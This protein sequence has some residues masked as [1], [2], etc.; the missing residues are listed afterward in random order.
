MVLVQ[1]LE[2]FAQYVAP[3]DNYTAEP[4]VLDTQSSFWSK[5]APDPNF[6]SPPSLSDEHEKKTTRFHSPTTT[7]NT[8]TKPSLLCDDCQAK[9]CS[10]CRACVAQFDWNATTTTTP[11]SSNAKT[12]PTTK[13]L[14]SSMKTPRRSSPPSNPALEQRVLSANRQTASAKDL[15]TTTAAKPDRSF[16]KLSASSAAWTDQQKKRFIKNAKKR[17][18]LLRARSFNLGQM[19]PDGYTP[20]MATAYNNNLDGLETIMTVASDQKQHPGAVSPTELLLETDP[21]GQSALHIC[22][23]RGHVEA[24]AFIKQ[25]MDEHGLPVPL[26]LLGKTPLGA[27]L[28]SPDPKAVSNRGSMK[29]LLY[30]DTDL[31]IVGNACPADER[32]LFGHAKVSAFAGTSEVPGARVTTEDYILTDSSLGDVLLLAVIDGHSDRGC[33]AKLVAER[34]IEGMS[35][36]IAENVPTENSV[37]EAMGTIVCLE[38]DEAVVDSG[39][40]GGA[41][42]VLVVVTETQVV[43]LNVGDCRCILVQNKGS[44]GS[45]EKFQ[46]VPLSTDHKP[47]D[48]KEYTRIKEAGLDVVDETFQEDGTDIPTFKIVCGKNK[49]AV[50]RAF[51]DFE[52]KA[53]KTLEKDEQAVIAVPQVTVHTRCSKDWFL[54][55]ACDGI[56]D[57]MESNEV[58][59]FLSD[60]LERLPTLEPTVLPT[61]CDALLRECLKRNAQDNLS[62]VI[63]A[64]CEPSSDFVEATS[65]NIPPTK[66]DFSST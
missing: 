36:R 38:A 28:T 18:G 30:S 40:S 29:K 19:C 47:N 9:L 43:V 66:L 56:W 23:S 8:S 42:G 2:R 59:A 26:D 1:W 41:V 12:H 45:T 52:F 17:P 33:V 6:Q 4:D 21:H 14:L 24:S 46:V 27:A 61:S 22:S 39:L 55:A 58:A 60:K 15:A 25:K 65:E 11:T 49:L 7:K 51:G 50:A 3:D 32:L 64:L 35:S 5:V 16:L 63:V 48:S 57:V 62:A 44:D 37:W 20:L 10:S 13:T 31:S 53:N 54:V 34:L